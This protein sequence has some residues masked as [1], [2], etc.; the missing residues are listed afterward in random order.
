MAT[1]LV[2]L[3]G[4]AAGATLSSS[5]PNSDSVPSR[6]SISSS[7]RSWCGQSASADVRT[8]QKPFLAF[9]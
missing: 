6:L 8:T 2:P 4:A 3:G 7:S 9:L 5:V 1:P